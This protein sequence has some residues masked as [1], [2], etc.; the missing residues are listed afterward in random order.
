MITW[1]SR[2]IIKIIATFIYIIINILYMIIL[3]LI[4]NKELIKEFNLLDNTFKIIW[5]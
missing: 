5:Q 4:Y 3:L 2:T 1:I